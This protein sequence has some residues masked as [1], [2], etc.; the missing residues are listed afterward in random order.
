MTIELS[1][2]SGHRLKANDILAGQTVA[3]PRCQAKV[4]IPQPAAPVSEQT[5]LEFLGPAKKVA[6]T[7]AGPDSGESVSPPGAES[8]PTLLRLPGRGGDLKDCPK[9]KREVH[10]GFQICPHCKTY[11]TNIKEVRRRMTGA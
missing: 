6:P 1:C 8:G 11:F 10:A 7:F 2:P 4:K 3:C 9:C 5:I